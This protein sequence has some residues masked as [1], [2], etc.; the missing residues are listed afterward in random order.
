MTYIVLKALLNSNQPTRVTPCYI[1]VESWLYLGWKTNQCVWC[2]RSDA[3]SSTMTSTSW[4]RVLSNQLQYR[5][6]W[7]LHFPCHHRGRCVSLDRL[8]TL[9]LIVW[10]TVRLRVQPP[11]CSTHHSTCFQVWWAPF[12]SR[13]ALTSCAECRV[14]YTKLFC[15]FCY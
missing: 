7:L 3:T 4:S 14:R 13:L 8:V 6:R 5:S 2:T 9:R 1:C 12:H 11:C 15:V 10:L